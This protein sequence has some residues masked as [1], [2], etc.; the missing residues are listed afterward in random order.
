MTISSKAKR[1]IGRH[2][3]LSAFVAVLVVLFI[4]VAWPSVYWAY[5][6]EATVVD[7]D[8]GTPLAGVV[9]VANWEISGGL[10]FPESA[11]VGELMVMEAVTDKAGRFHFPGWGPKLIFF[12]NRL[13]GAA[14]QL[15]L[16]KPNYD[17]KVVNNQ[18]FHAE[19]VMSAESKSVWDGRRIDLDRFRGSAEQ[20]AQRFSAVI[21]SALGFIQEFPEECIWKKVP[22]VLS[23][24]LEERRILR[25]QGVR[26]F[27]SLD[28]QL[29][30]NSGWYMHRNPLCGSPKKFL[31]ELRS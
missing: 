29:K 27:S 14:P 24:V 12:H 9:V 3:V 18:W 8:T 1:F 7:K 30:D 2:K 25:E 20:Y 26:N 11:P 31:Q 16:F 13:D 28:D 5:P 17:L 21:S 6:I 15:F 19:I 10:N 22:R 4:L 23:A